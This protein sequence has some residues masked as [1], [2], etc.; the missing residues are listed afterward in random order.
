[1]RKIL[2]ILCIVGITCGGVSSYAAS[3]A[4]D[5]QEMRKYIDESGFI[6]GNYCPPPGAIKN[7]VGSVNQGSY[8]C[9]T[10]CLVQ[11][12]RGKIYK[13]GCLWKPG[14]WLEVRCF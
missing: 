6:T 4:Q 14:H 12:P 10:E 13:Q 8:G 5:G 9:S 11:G 7:L 2:H 1:M 3:C